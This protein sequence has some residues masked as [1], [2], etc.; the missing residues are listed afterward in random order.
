MIAGL[1]FD[2]S[3]FQRFIAKVLDRPISHFLG[4]AALRIADNTVNRCREIRNV[5]IDHDDRHALIHRLLEQGCRRKLVMGAEDNCVHVL[6][7]NILDHTHLTVD[8]GTALRCEHEHL[9]AFFFSHGFD[10]FADGDVVVELGRR[11]HIG[12]AVGFV[13]RLD[14]VDRRLCTFLQRN[15]FGVV[16]RQGG[17]CWKRECGHDGCRFQ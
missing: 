7:Q 14:C 1:A 13:L 9:Y 2:D 17:V 5:R 16:L 4:A 12:D 8:V 3:H 15:R 11:R 6:G 10:A